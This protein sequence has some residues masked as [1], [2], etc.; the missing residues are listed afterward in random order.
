MGCIPPSPESLLELRELQKRVAE[1]GDEC[2]SALLA[3]VATYV[4][5][6]RE[7]ELLETMR[8]FAHDAQ[9]MVNKTPSA[10]ELRRMFEKD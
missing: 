10:D 5:V 4:A 7:W 2:L 1:R 9:E 6:G 3:G 8:K